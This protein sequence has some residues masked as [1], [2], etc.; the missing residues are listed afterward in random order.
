MVPGTPQMLT[1]LFMVT[2]VITVVSAASDKHATCGIYYMSG[3][4]LSVSYVLWAYP[5]SSLKHLTRASLSGICGSS[6]ET[7]Y[8]KP[9]LSFQFCWEPE[10][11]KN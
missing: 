8:G 10:T 1:T 4:V 3:I 2:V 11:H 6:G 9:L 7:G 5:I